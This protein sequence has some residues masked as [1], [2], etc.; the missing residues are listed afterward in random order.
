MF[1]NCIIICFAAVFL[2]GCSTL[3]DFYKAP[4]K[5]VPQ[6]GVKKLTAGKAHTIANRVPT[7]GIIRLARIDGKKLYYEKDDFDDLMKAQILERDRFTG[8][9][10]RLTEFKIEFAFTAKDGG[11]YF[12]EG[13]QVVEIEEGMLYEPAVRFDEREGVFT[14]WFE[15]TSTGLRASKPS[16]GDWQKLGSSS[17]VAIMEDW[18][19]RG[20][21]MNPLD[22]HNAARERSTNKVIEAYERAVN[23][24]MQD[25]MDRSNPNGRYQN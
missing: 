15:N 1:R 11:G 22:T 20:P 25:A 17:F 16:Q 24:S 23:A 12:C 9:S 5:K 7:S 10:A 3:N 2:S 19:Q 4:S 13:Q 21:T 6:A 18:M 14:F 8:V